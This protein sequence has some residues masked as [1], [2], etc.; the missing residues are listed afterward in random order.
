ML[1]TIDILPSESHTCSHFSARVTHLANLFLSCRS[2]R[3]EIIAGK[4][5]ITHQKIRES[6]SESEIL[7]IIA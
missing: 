2:Y 5:Q 1:R 3:N 7:N 4:A 6:T